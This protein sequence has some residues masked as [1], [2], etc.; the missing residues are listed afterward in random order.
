EATRGLVEQ[1]RVCGF[2]SIN[3]DLIYGLPYQTEPSFSSTIDKILALSP[4]RLAVYSYAH[5]PWM[6]KHQDTLAP[7]LPTEQQ[8]F[9]I[10][11]LALKRFMDAGFVYIGMDHFAKPT[12]E[13]SIARENGTLWRNFMGYT[14]KAGTDLIGF[15]MS[16]IGRVGNTFVQNQR[17]LAAYQDDLQRIGAATLRGFELNQDDL[18][19]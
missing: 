5:V 15:G 11:M 9:N 1:A 16:A 12:D 4:D 6:K 14:T 3:M 7:H 19:R 18:I 17:E 10:F 13:L 2:H 8:K